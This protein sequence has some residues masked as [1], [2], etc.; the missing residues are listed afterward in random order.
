MLSPLAGRPEIGR[1]R[2]RILQQ[3]R[4]RTTMTRTNKWLIGIALVGAAAGAA[5]LGLFWLVLT[6]PVA[7]AQ[8]IDRAL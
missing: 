3:E 6:R 5:A 8:M 7:I 1:V 2:V 4:R